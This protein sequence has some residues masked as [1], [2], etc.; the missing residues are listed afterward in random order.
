MA[1]RLGEQIISAFPRIPH[2]PAM[3]D[4]S[5]FFLGTIQEYVAVIKGAWSP[6]CPLTPV[7][8]S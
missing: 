7:C 4:D 2:P 1:H 8:A 6:S 5:G 3:S